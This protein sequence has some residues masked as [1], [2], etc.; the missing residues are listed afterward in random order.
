[1]NTEEIKQLA[2]LSSLELDPEETQKV[3]QELE[4]IFNLVNQ[5]QAVST[6][7]VEPLFHPIALIAELNQPLRLD[8]VTES[9]RREENMASAPAPHQGLYLVPKVIE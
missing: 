1:M 8:E 5:L 2:K 3:S 6:E 4:T 9:D 7:G